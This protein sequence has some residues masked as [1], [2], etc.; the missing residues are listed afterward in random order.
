MA[1][2]PAPD[3]NSVMIAVFFTSAADMGIKKK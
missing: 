1:G 3:P 2:Q